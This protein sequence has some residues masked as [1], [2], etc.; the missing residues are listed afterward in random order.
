MAVVMVVVGDGRV[1]G[2]GDDGGREGRDDGD[3]GNGITLR[4]NVK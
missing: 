4:R 3:G 1:D 2:G